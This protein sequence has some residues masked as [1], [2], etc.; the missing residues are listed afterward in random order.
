MG[1]SNYLVNREF[2]N[3]FRATKY[4][5]PT[6]I[7]V[8]LYLTDPGPTDTG[9]VVTGAGF[10]PLQCD[11]SDTNWTNTQGS[12]SG[13]SSG[14][15]RTITNAVQLT[16]AQPLASWGLVAY[17]VLRDAASGGNLLCSGALPQPL[18]VGPGDQ[19]PNFP[20]GSLIFTRP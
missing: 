7:W 9:T 15:S 18:L 6:H 12:T 4:A 1:T 13:A 2:D 11:P 3:L 5:G 14:S 20:P 16:F 8:F 10:A 19:P 17:A